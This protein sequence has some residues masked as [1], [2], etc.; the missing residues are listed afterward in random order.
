M[1]SIVN[2]QKTTQFDRYMRGKLVVKVPVCSWLRVATD[3]I[4]RPATA[5]TEFCDDEVN[6]PLLKHDRRIHGQIT[7][8]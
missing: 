4:N 3:Y 8:K 7:S 5:A 6:D 2:F 1:K